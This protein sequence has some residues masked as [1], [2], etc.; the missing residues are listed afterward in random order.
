VRILQR[1]PAAGADLRPV[2]GLLED[3]DVAAAAGGQEA[4]LFAVGRVVERHFVGVEVDE[5]LPRDHAEIEG[6]RLHI[7]VGLRRHDG[8]AFRRLQGF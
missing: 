8:V 5:V 4:N 2:A 6:Y 7:G 1:R 3:V